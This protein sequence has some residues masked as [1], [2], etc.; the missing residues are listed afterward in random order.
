[1]NMLSFAVGRSVMALVVA[2]S[3]IGI[4]VPASAAAE[5]G[6]QLTVAGRPLFG[7]VRPD[8][9]RDRGPG[10]SPLARSAGASPAGVPPKP[11]RV[12]GRVPRAVLLTRSRPSTAP[13]RSWVKRHPVLFGALV[14]TVAGAGI[15]HAKGGAE[16]AFVGFY[17]GAA[18]GS[19]VGWVV[20]R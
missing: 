18:A 13:N 15:V 10:G 2:L 12:D 7:P 1:M 20:S 6:G 3:V 8:Q 19:V 14:G 17:G 9:G 16:A 11:E 4:P 5:K